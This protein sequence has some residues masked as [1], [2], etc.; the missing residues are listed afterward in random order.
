MNAIATVFAALFLS[1]SVF[2]TELK[3]V[4]LN[5]ESPFVTCAIEKALGKLGSKY[6]ILDVMG[7]SLANTNKPA[8]LADLKFITGNTQTGLKK[9]FKLTIRSLDTKNGWQT[10]TSDEGSYIF[11]TK[12]SSV[13]ALKN[14][15]SKIADLDLSLCP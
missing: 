7:G 1:S 3:D 10:R 11:S 14:S 13:V 12:V 5:T 2:A 4:S 6:E 15:S 9:S 8:L